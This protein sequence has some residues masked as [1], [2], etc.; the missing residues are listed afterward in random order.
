MLRLV[1]ESGS[2]N[3]NFGQ[4]FHEMI[5]EILMS[6]SMTDTRI[7]K[8]LD[9]QNIMYRVDKDLDI[10]KY[11]SFFD[12][13]PDIKKPNF[14]YAHAFSDW[15]LSGEETL[16]PKV[17]ELNPIAAKFDA[18]QS[19]LSGFELPA[20]FSMFYGPRIKSQLSEVV[21]E[22]VEFPGTRRAYISVL[23]GETDNLLLSSLRNGELPTVEYPCTIGFNFR[24]R[25]DGGVRKLDMTVFMRSQNMYTVWPYDYLINLKL[26]HAVSKAT[27]YEIGS[28]YGVVSSAHIYERDFG[29]AIK[30]SGVGLTV[31]ELLEEEAE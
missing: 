17:V 28:L 26:F 31:K 16:D 4:V 25:K 24:T 10:E 7:G 20:N 5:F 14:A 18:K 19:D 3:R 9:I 27:G 22:L 13:G 8:S 2:D 21:K 11:E 12:F 6:G 23:N 1:H 30:V 15:V 29:N